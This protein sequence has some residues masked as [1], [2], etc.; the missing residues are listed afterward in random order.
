M[1]MRPSTRKSSMLIVLL[2]M[3]ETVMNKVQHKQGRDHAAQP[4]GAVG[5]DVPH[6]PATSPAG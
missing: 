5:V 1:G 3:R 4:S 6:S 2:K